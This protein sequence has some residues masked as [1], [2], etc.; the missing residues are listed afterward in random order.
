MIHRQ[1]LSTEYISLE[2]NRTARELQYWSWFNHTGWNHADY[3]LFVMFSMRYD[4][5]P[6][7]VL[8][9]LSRII[10]WNSRLLESALI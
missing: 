3:L 2:T 4:I 1:I 8:V 10:V 9:S 6:S 7:F 5:I